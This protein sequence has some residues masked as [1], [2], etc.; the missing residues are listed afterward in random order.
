ME[1]LSITT[2]NLN[3]V[4]SEAQIS[5]GIYLI[6]KNIIIYGLLIVYG[7]PRVTTLHYRL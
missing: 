5:K 7:V 4:S 2:E 1:S 3:S 6:L